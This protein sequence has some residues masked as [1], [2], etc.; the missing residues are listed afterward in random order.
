MALSSA[1][2]AQFIEEI[3]TKTGA[4]ESKATAVVHEVKDSTITPDHLV[5]TTAKG[6]TGKFQLYQLSNGPGEATNLFAQEPAK[7]MELFTALQADIARG[8]SRR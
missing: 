5:E 1:S 3:A 4:T 7:A 8:R 6:A 2:L